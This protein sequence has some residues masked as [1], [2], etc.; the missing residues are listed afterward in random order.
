MIKIDGLEDRGLRD[1]CFKILSNRVLSD[2]E[3][4]PPPGTLVLSSPCLYGKRSE[5]WMHA[6]AR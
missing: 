4:P 2:R 1:D 3:N 6:Q 5:Y